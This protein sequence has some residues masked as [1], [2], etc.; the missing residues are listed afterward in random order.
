MPQIPRINKIQPSSSTPSNDRIK[1]NVSSNA[2]I[3]NNN[4][5][6][7]VG[8]ASDVADLAY[9]AENEAIDQKSSE[10]NTKYRQRQSEALKRV[11]TNEGDPSESYAKYDEEEVAYAKELEES[12]S[13]LSSRAKRIVTERFNKSRQSVSSFSSSQRELQQNVYRDKV[14]NAE[15]SIMKKTFLFSLLVSTLKTVEHSLNSI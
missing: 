6:S 7:L 1:F 3:V 8:L 15:K 5:N 9:K 13:G 11:K 10:I 14:Y 4:M 12:L 2:S